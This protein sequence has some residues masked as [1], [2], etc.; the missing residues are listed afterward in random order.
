MSKNLIE[1]CRGGLNPRKR[2]NRPLRATYLKRTHGK[3]S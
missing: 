1:P 3:S 2:S